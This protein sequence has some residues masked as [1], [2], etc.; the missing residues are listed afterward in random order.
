M[1]YN[2]LG[3][4]EDRY[5]EKQGVKANVTMRPGHY[6]TLRI[7]RQ[8]ILGYR[9]R[10]YELLIGRGKHLGWIGLWF[11]PPPKHNKMLDGTVT[12]KAVLC[13]TKIKAYKAM[14]ANVFEDL[15]YVV[16][17]EILYVKL[18]HRQ[19]LVEQGDW[20]MALPDVRDNPQDKRAEIRD[21]HSMWG[22]GGAPE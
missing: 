3:R 1:F 15:T 22:D 19:G 7:S 2:K 21:M 10:S 8:L 6:P 4:L 12:E 5:P 17:K 9:H 18:P 13:T 11:D 14:K 20:W 16:T